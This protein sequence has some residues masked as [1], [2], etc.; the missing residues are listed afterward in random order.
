MEIA[1]AALLAEVAEVHPEG[2]IRLDPARLFD[3]PDELALRTLARGIAVVGGAP[4]GPKA[5]ALERLHTEIAEAMRQKRAPP[6]RTLGGCR[7][8]PR[9]GALVVAREPDAAVERYG[10]A[11]GE[12]VWWDRRFTVALDPVDVGCG[13]RAPLSVTRLTVARLG[14]AG[15]R[16]ALSLWPVLAR[17]DLPESVRCALPGLWRGDTLVGVPGLGLM[18]EE[19]HLTARACFTPAV[20]LAGPAFSVVY[21]RAGII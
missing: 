2:W 16:A 17:H 7:I 13:T 6:A 18:A 8:L 5:E 20:A 1:T 3:A 4:Y 21:G 11:P 12:S 9:R 10:V 15:W 19:Q 14:A